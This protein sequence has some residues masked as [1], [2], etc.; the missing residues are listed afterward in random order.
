MYSLKKAC[1]S[2]REMLRVL[3]LY[4]E[5]AERD[6]SHPCLSSW[7]GAITANGTTTEDAALKQRPAGRDKVRQ[8]RQ[9]TQTGVR[10]KSHGTPEKQVPAEG[11]GWDGRTLVVVE[12][13]NKVKLGEAWSWKMQLWMAPTFFVSIIDTEGNSQLLKLWLLK[14]N[15]WHMKRLLLIPCNWWCV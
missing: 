11:G 5:A 6:F 2:P 7:P 13:G 1:A 14:F 9:P 12:A 3:H 4:A 10:E 15:V 8:Q